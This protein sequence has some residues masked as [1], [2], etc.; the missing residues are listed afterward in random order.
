MEYMYNMEGDVD[1]Q[2]CQDL[3]SPIRMFHPEALH[4]WGLAMHGHWVFPLRSNLH[5]TICSVQNTQTCCIRYASITG[6]DL[7][8]FIG[9]EV[10]CKWGQVE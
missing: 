1:V 4:N 2:P 9:H 10:H 8:S 6:T 5:N 7:L 3:C